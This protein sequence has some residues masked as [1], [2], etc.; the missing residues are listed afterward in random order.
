MTTTELMMIVAVL[1]APLIAV[2]VQKRLERWREGNERKKQIFK[3]LMATRAT[4][5]DPSHVTAL[6]MIDLEFKEKA[7]LEKWREYMDSLLDAPEI[8]SADAQES[9]QQT[10]QNDMKIWLDKG[11]DKFIDLLYEMSRALKYKF[12]KA[13]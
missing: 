2:D 10:Y 3:T 13:I 1:L 11:D 5:I 8:L 12:D 6:N 7:I 9:E 4:R